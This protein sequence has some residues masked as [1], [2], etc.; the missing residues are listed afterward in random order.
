MNYRALPEAREDILRISNLYD[1]RSV[2]LG[3][4]FLAEYDALI[5]RILA[6]PRLCSRV[7]RQPRGREIRQGSLKRFPFVLIYEVTP[8]EIVVLAVTHNRTKRRS[9][10]RRL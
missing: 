2:A 1:R 10:R 5:Q 9:W 8:S 3:N 4:K 6:Q 7:S